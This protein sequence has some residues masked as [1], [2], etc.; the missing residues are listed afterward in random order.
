MNAD[1]NERLSRTLNRAQQKSREPNALFSRIRNFTS[2]F[3][4]SANISGDKDSR[5]EYDEEDLN[6]QEFWDPALELQ[7]S[8]NA[9]RQY[10]H[11]NQ[12]LAPPIMGLDVDTPTPTRPTTPRNNHTRN[13]PSDKGIFNQPRCDHNRTYYRDFHDYRD[14]DEGNQG[15][16]ALTNIESHA[17]VSSSSSTTVVASLSLHSSLSSASS[18]SSSDLNDTPPLSPDGGSSIGGFP[19]ILS[20]SEELEFAMN[21]DAEQGVYYQQF[22]PDDSIYRPKEIKE[23][24]KPER[25]VVRL[26]NLLRMATHVLSTSVMTRSSTTSLE[27]TLI[28]RPPITKL[29]TDPSSTM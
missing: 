4:N 26:F 5:F 21:E 19:S 2:L 22:Q 15:G 28:I 9:Q 12:H 18:I 25:A 29:I 27:T 20:L 17:L 3:T 11:S 23:G 10:H 6:G 24:K 16:I 14:Y 13:N 8:T 1:V 7:L